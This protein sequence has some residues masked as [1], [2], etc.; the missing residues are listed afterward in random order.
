MVGHLTDD[1]I[2][3]GVDHE[4]QGDGPRHPLRRQADQLVVEEQQERLEPRVLDP[5]GDGAEAVGKLGRDTQARPLANC[6]RYGNGRRWAAAG[7]PCHV[8][9]A[10]LERSTM[11]PGRASVGWPSSWI[12]SPLTTVAT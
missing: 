7:K 10:R 2:D 5:E 1:R 12:A 9:A 8:E 4:R 11:Q 6:G 3:A